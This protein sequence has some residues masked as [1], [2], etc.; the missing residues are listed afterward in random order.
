VVVGGPNSGLDDPVAAM[1]RSG[2]PPQKCWIDDPGSW[3]TNEVT[4]GWNAALAL[5]ANHV[6]THL[7]PPRS[8]GTP[9]AA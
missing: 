1:A 6:A 7:A 5:V 4:I 3:A 8:L 2:A 9:R